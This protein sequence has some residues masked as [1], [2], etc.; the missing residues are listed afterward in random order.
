MAKL[1]VRR[2]VAR[3]DLDILALVDDWTNRLARIT[4]PRAWFATP[5]PGPRR[6][7]PRPSTRSNAKAIAR[8]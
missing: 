4:G 8:V 3:L 2:R 7:G 5:T 1:I 6:L